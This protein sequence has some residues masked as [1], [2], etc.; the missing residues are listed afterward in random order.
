MFR[1][2]IKDFLLML[3]KKMFISVKGQ[4]NLDNTNFTQFLSQAHIKVLSGSYKY[5]FQNLSQKPF[6]AALT[7]HSLKTQGKAPQPTKICTNRS[8]ILVYLQNAWGLNIKLLALYC[9][10]QN[11]QCTVGAIYKTIDFYYLSLCL[12]CSLPASWSLSDVL[13][14]AHGLDW[15]WW[16]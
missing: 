6:W 9:C 3:R 13:D 10:V 11:T 15:S 1:S 4:E 7:S 14:C 16:D 2:E 8:L 12:S 5:Y